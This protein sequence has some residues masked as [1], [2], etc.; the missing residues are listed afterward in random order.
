M[1]GIGF[2][3]KKL[4][5]KEGIFNGLKASVYSTIVTIGPTLISIA[6]IISFN[7]LLKFF[8]VSVI[9]R[10][11]FQVTLMYSFVFAFILTSG[12]SMV[13]SRYIADKIF[14]KDYED[15]RASLYGSI[16]TIV[17]IGS[18]VGSIFYWKSD[19]PLLYKLFAYSLF[20]ENIIQIVLSTYVTALKNVKVIVLGFVI[21]FIISIICGNVVYLSI[22]FF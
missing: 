10:D 7:M 17:G 4:F 9:K 16:V 3:L 13:L 2:E 8:G 19:L 5:K 12:Y 6:L 11:L 21:S 1:A 20:I 15:I 22:L 18:I 14:V